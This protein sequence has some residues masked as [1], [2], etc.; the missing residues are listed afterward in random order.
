[1]D[2]Y[3]GTSFKGQVLKEHMP[4]RNYINSYNRE[5]EL[6]LSYEKQGYYAI[7]A[8]GSHGVADVIALR[9]IRCGHR[10]ACP[11]VFQV[12]FIQVKVSQ[13]IREKKVTKKAEEVP[14]GFV[15]VEYHY[16]PVKNAKYRE[17]T[18]KRKEKVRAKKSLRK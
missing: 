11:D 4:N 9:P 10:C 7:R 12:N 14:F 13:G 1:M 6:K 8:A 3:I 5:N 17:E 15:N 2:D 16:F 18:R